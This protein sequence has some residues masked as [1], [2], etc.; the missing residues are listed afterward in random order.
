MYPCGIGSTLSSSDTSGVLSG[1][2]FCQGHTLLP[3][4]WLDQGEQTVARNFLCSPCSYQAQSEV[5]SSWWVCVLELRVCQVCLNHWLCFLCD[6]WTLRVSPCWRGT[7][8][9]CR[10]QWTP[11]LPSVEEMSST[12]FWWAWAV[13]CCFQVVTS[14]PHIQELSI[15]LSDSTI[16]G[17]V[18]DGYSFPLAWEDQLGSHCSSAAVMPLPGGMG[19]I[20]SRSIDL[21][22]VSRGGR[23]V[24]IVFRESTWV[25]DTILVFAVKHESGKKTVYNPKKRAFSP[26]GVT[27]GHG[28]HPLYICSNYAADMVVW[29]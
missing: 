24:W 9:L 14:H 17:H 4:V 25:W 11:C 19:F 21:Q 7:L 23:S 5:R 16:A 3:N 2:P 28:A 10:M 22:T 15:Y 1:C 13:L 18:G 26:V 6:R 8:W 20:C 29:R 12:S 27:W